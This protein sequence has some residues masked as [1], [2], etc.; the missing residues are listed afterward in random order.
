MFKSTW[1]AMLTSGEKKD[2]GK[3]L[4]ILREKL[5][6]ISRTEPRIELG[7]SQSK[8]KNSDV[9]ELKRLYEQK[10]SLY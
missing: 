8:L 2:F 1:D 3:S 7:M 10:Q 5:R 4:E 6:G 9:E